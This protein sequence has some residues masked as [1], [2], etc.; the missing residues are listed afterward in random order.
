MGNG[1]YTKQSDVELVINLI[2]SIESGILETEV[3]KYIA[4]YFNLDKNKLKEV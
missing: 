4:P 1:D 3:N 2:I